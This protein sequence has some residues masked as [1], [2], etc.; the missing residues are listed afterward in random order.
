M[1]RSFRFGGDAVPEIG[2][3]PPSRTARAVARR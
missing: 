1:E 2:R 3:L